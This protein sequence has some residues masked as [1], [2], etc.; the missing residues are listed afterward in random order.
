LGWGSISHLRPD[1]CCIETLRQFRQLTHGPILVSWVPLASSRKKRSFCI[2]DGYR[3]WFTGEEISKMAGDAGLAVVDY[4]D[5]E[6]WAVLRVA[7]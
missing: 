6:N 3:R 7:N 1:Q 4:D 5:D 2:Y